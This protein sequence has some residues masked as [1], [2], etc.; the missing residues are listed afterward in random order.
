MH[1]HMLN[2]FDCTNIRTYEHLSSVNTQ[3]DEKAAPHLM[4]LYSL[5]RHRRAAEPWVTDT[6][7][8]IVDIDKGDRDPPTSSAGSEA[9]FAAGGDKGYQNHGRTVSANPEQGRDESMTHESL[10]SLRKGGFSIAL[11]NGD[12]LSGLSGAESD[13]GEREK[14]LLVEVNMRSMISPEEALATLASFEDSNQACHTQTKKMT[15]Q[16]QVSIPSL[17]RGREPARFSL[18]QAVAVARPATV[19]AAT[20][21]FANGRHPNPFDPT[22]RGVGAAESSQREDADDNDSF[23][24]KNRSFGRALARQQRTEDEHVPVRVHSQAS[25]V[26]AA[27]CE[28]DGIPWEFDPT[29]PRTLSTESTKI[30]FCRLASADKRVFGRTASPRSRNR[31]SGPNRSPEAR[32]QPQRNLFTDDIVSKLQQV[33]M[34]QW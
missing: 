7:V 8:H 5:A 25:L 26:P 28:S 3:A 20:A 22:Q 6:D 27:P 1:A 33:G 19:A 15:H 9:G 32:R 21:S 34:F 29:F 14:P 30:E 12:F 11:R 16:Q 23:S 4:L 13:G 31:E 10:S 2:F 18:A 17:N 24:T